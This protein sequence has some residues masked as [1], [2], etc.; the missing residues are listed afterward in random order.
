MDYELK[1]IERLKQARIKGNLKEIFTCNLNLKV[2]R[3]DDI[4][5]N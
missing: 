5:G 3:G 4:N 1:L 2:W